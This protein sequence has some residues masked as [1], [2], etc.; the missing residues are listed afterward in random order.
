MIVNQEKLRGYG[1][2]IFLLND[3][4]RQGMKQ[5]LYEEK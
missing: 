2:I 1:W 3:R 5:L 4:E